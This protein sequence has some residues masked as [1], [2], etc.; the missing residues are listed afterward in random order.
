[1]DVLSEFETIRICTGYRYQGRSLEEV[2]SQ[3]EILRE[4][5]PVYEE[6]PGWKADLKNARNFLDLP[7]RAHDYVRRIEELTE[8]EV[9]L[10]SV[11]ERREE[12]I[13]RRNPFRR[14]PSKS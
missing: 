12:T 4:C 2:P 6:H 1:M 5:E 9:V 13:L 14:G 10:V 3:I 7:P 11:G 8:T